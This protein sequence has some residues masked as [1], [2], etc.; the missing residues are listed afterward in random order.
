MAATVTATNSSSIGGAKLRAVA[1]LCASI[2]VASIGDVALAAWLGIGWGP[3]SAYRRIGP[4]SGPQVFVAGS[5]LTQFGL[6]WPEVSRFMGQGVEN[7]GV[8]ASS[9]DIWEVSQRAA[10]NADST[11]IGIS[12][13]DLNEEHLSEARAR[14]VPLSQTISDLRHSGADWEL[15]RRL[16]DQ[17][18]TACIR[19]AFPTAGLTDKVQVALRA[20]MREL[21]GSS[22][23]A[24]DRENELVLPT[25]PILEFGDSTVKVSD[26]D[27]ARM[28]RR[29]ALLR[30]EN[31]GLHRF[32]G[33][34]NLAF[35]RM[36]LRAHERGAVI[37]VVLPVTDAYLD[38]FLTADVNRRFEQVLAEARHV[39]P[40]ATVVRLDR[41]P[42]LTSN[43]DFSDLVHLNSDGRR[44]ATDA[45]LDQVRH[46]PEARRA[47]R[48]TP[49]VASAR[50]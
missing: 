26:W 27:E 2:L 21:V 18:V 30:A 41:V 13:Y 29:V 46:F 3:A 34:K 43:R 28:V 15:S 24:Q 45:F 16:L 33:P 42:G 7:W 4:E 22:L 44:I 31:H 11:I 1:I 14:V 17:Y 10:T 38:A 48:Q 6:S 8:V 50:R 40:E 39:L 47:F 35:K 37:I 32:D 20:K 5:S 12:V 9:P 49:T 25:R 36:L 19:L 23:A